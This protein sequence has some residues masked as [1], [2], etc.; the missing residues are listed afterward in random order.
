MGSRVEEGYTLSTM[1]DAY[2][3]QGDD[4]RAMATYERALAV[5]RSF[6]ARRGEGED[7]RAVDTGGAFVNVGGSGRQGDTLDMQPVADELR[8]L[9]DPKHRRSAGVRLRGA[10]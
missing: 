3:Q 2:V 4:A 7:D 8:V 1:G 10:L 6:G 5:W 9:A